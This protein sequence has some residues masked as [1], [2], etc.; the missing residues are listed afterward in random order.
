LEL[1]HLRYFFIVAREGSFTRAAKILRVQQP[2]ISKMVQRLESQL[3]LVLLERHKRGVQ[4]TKVGADV[5]RICEA[6]FNGVEQIQEIS[7]S[8]RTECQGLLSLGMTDSASIYLL[9][10]LLKEFLRQNPKVRPSIFTGS[11]NLITNEIL[12][13]RVEF[14]VYF[15]KPEREDLRISELVQVPFQLVISTKE[16]RNRSL[17]TRF[18]ISRDIDYPK[19][20]EFPV[21]EMLKKNRI[22]IDNMIASN[23][24]E[25]QKYMVLQGLG[26]ALLPS[27]MVK[28]DLARGALA[29]LHEDKKFSYSLKVVTQARRLPSRNAMVFLDLMRRT[30]GSFL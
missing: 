6:V 1:N 24:L 4:L 23:N 9:P 8:E 15:S 3:N 29:Q 18:V 22:K 30:I 20:R 12:D 17:H 14:G 7:D 27:F 2:T 25:S 28:S 19:S 13:G 16:L 26:I 21:L 10:P 5:F 11:Y